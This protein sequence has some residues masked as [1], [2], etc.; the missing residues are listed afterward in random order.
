MKFMRWSWR[1]YCE[2]PD[3]YRDVLI[4]VIREES[5]AM[6]MAAAMADAKRR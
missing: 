3:F 4:E 6:E 1:D 2:L 5:H